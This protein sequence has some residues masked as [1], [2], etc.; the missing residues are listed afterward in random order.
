MSIMRSNIEMNNGQDIMIPETASA[1]LD[2][3]GVRFYTPENDVRGTIINI[4]ADAT[5]IYGLGE[6]ST[7]TFLML[8]QPHDEEFLNTDEYKNAKLFFMQH[9]HFLW[10]DLEH[11]GMFIM[12]YQN[13]IHFGIV[14]G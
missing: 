11:G 3:E 12:R 7:E 5:I 6:M 9:T 4:Q 8:L 2:D 13:A 1:T 10:G 14:Y